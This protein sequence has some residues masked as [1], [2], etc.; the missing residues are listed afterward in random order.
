MERTLRSRTDKPCV[1]SPGCGIKG[2][3]GKGH[4][5]GAKRDR[6]HGPGNC[7][8]LK[9]DGN[10]E[11]THGDSPL[12]DATNINK[13]KEEKATVQN[14]RDSSSAKKTVNKKQWSSKIIAFSESTKRLT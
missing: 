2:C 8:P 9:S 1:Y 12:P 6:H 5:L 7:P 10:T 3:N 13:V 14:E 11:A 4:I